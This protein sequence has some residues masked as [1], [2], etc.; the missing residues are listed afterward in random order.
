VIVQ[1]SDG[2]FRFAHTLSGPSDLKRALTALAKDARYAALVATSA[3]PVSALYA[4]V[5]NHR[6]FTGRSGTMYKYEGLGCIYWHMVS[7]LLVAVAEVAL[8]ARERGES[9]R[10][11]AETWHRLRAGLGVMK[12]PHEFG[13]FPIDPYSHTP[14]HLGA[15]Q[16]G[17]T[18]QAKEG[19]LL[20]LGELGVT[21]RHGRLGFDP[22]LLRPSERLTQPGRFE[23]R[24]VDGARRECPLSP[25]SLAFTFCQV[26]VIYR[27]A[28]GAPEIHVVGRDGAIRAVPGRR[29]DRETSAAIF[30]RRGSVARL[31][32]F[33]PEHA[34]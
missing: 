18:G 5:F 1:A 34:L 24:D 2:T 8:A 25:G 10:E 32:V 12:T 14:A 33:C 31:E 17:M 26:P 16:P 27:I 6:A 23:F 29:L 21:V 15:Q 13:A 4:D 7:K 28:S 19:V 11:L 3:E 30:E 22:F 20:R 9:V